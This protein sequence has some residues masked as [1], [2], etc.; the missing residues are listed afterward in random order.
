MSRKRRVFDIDMPAMAD[1]QTGKIPDEVLEKRRGPM[2]AAISENA[3]ALRNK[4]STEDVIRAEN[5]R[6]AHELVR[7]RAEGL[8]TERIALESVVS[9]KLTRDR[10]PGPDPELEELKAS[11]REIGLSN[12]IRVERRPDGRYDLIQGMRR[13]SAYQALC[14]ETG[15][16]AFA[17]IP[18][19]IAD[20]ADL[21]D[22]YRRMV[23][24]NLIRKD[25]SFAEMGALARA[26]AEDPA[27]ECPDVD[28]AVSTLFKSASYTKR[29]YIR[30]FSALL[31]KMDK[32]LMHPND[33]PRNVGVELKRKLDSD[34][35]LI[36]K[37]GAAL[38]SEP[39]RDS[40]REIAILRGVMAQE[41]VAPAKSKSEGS[42]KPRRAKT[43][44]QVP[45]RA[46]VAKCSAS[47]GRI[48]VRYNLD[49]TRVDR[50][51]LE[52][53]IATLIEDLQEDDLTHG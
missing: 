3:E 7:L 4:Q 47:S 32:L 18:A 35:G 27:N 33:I 37:V 6:L 29:S 22:S 36:R 40:A 16:E 31:T 17:T 28:K 10:K 1:I 42:A 13:L 38:M 21:D 11:I 48:D 15:D 26:Y 20:A 12:P 39:D 14:Q 44:F 2:A 43:T 50:A 34:P 51:R 30:A 53:A 46:G 24:E 25:I 45:G 19:A 49:F 23:D 8:V 9:E 5:D 41:T 52:Q